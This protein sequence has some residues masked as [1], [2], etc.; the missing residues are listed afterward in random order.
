MTSPPDDPPNKAENEINVAKELYDAENGVADTTVSDITEN[1]EEISSPRGGH[2]IFDHPELHPELH[3]TI[4]LKAI[5]SNTP[6]E[7]KYRE[8]KQQPYDEVVIP[9]DDLYSLSWEGDFD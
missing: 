7:D 6:L 9:Q 4:R 5:V 2:I 3:S 1:S 8:E